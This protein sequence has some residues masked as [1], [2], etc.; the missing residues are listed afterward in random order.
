MKAYFHPS[1]SCYPASLSFLFLLFHHPH[2]PYGFVPS[3]CN[4]LHITLDVWQD[5][6]Y[7]FARNPRD[8]KEMVFVNRVIFE[9]YY[10]LVLLEI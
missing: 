4:I 10:I 9:R 3:A 6:I 8:E 1:V 5:K 2:Q 7:C